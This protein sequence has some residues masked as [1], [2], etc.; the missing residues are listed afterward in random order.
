MRST[1][2]SC[3]RAPCGKVRAYASRSRRHCAAFP[4]ERS[5][6]AW[7]MAAISGSRDGEGV[8]LLLC[9]GAVFV[10]VEDTDGSG[11]TTATGEAISTELDGATTG[12]TATV[13]EGG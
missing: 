11:A 4:E 6:R 2:A 1:I 3:A 12:A 5:F 9:G 13:T 8:V 10:G 7:S